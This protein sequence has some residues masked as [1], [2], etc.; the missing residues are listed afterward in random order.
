MNI[1]V[2]KKEQFMNMNNLELFQFVYHEIY[3]MYGAICM[4]LRQQQLHEHSSTVGCVHN[5]KQ[6]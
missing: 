6:R 4:Q 2:W 1:Y 3:A 5:V